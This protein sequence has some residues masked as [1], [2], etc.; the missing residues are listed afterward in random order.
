MTNMNSGFPHWW[1]NPDFVQPSQRQTVDPTIYDDDLRQIGDDN[2]GNNRQEQRELSA[3]P[4][5]ETK[6][7]LLAYLREM[8]PQYLAEMQASQAKNR[9]YGKIPAQDGSNQI[10]KIRIKEI[11]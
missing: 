11:A 1:L 2:K 10:K 9:S 8:T 7:A 5:R 6:E 4:I 3:E